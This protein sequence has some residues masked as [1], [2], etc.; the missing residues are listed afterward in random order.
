M[1]YKLTEL[2]LS[3]S[4]IEH[5]KKDLVPR[6]DYRSSPAGK[7]TFFVLCSIKPVL[8]YSTL[9]HDFGTSVLHRVGVRTLPSG[10]PAQTGIGLIDG[11]GLSPYI[12]AGLARRNIWVTTLSRDRMT[13]GSAVAI[14]MMNAVSNSLSTYA[15]VTSISSTS[16]EGGFPQPALLIGST[17]YVAG[18]LTELV[19]EIQRERFKADP[20]NKGKVCTG[21]LW[22][23]ARHINY[24][25]YMMWR[26]GYAMAGGGYRLGVLVAAF[27]A[28]DFS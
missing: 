22:S 23:L 11:L 9:A 20:H 18:I 21:G 28:W 14:A 1:Y 19:V 17:L 15:S 10:L 7:I 13:V 16:T 24:G 12:L 5:P 27:W 6:G 8:Q 4:P 25:G 3:S 26:A 2:V